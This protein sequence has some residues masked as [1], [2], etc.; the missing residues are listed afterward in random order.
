MC[1]SGARNVGVLHLCAAPS[2]TL[3]PPLSSAFV[4]SLVS[5]ASTHTFCSD[6]P[7]VE[8]II[9]GPFI[10]NSLAPHCAATTRANNVLP[11]PAV[12]AHNKVLRECTDSACDI[13]ALKMMWI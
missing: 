12:V 4:M 6:A 5:L 7:R 9:S 13:K 10:R 2:Y 1:V 3:V 8:S 11:Q